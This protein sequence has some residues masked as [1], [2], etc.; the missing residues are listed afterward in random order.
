MRARASHELTM[1]WSTDE[2]R[3]R[4]AE[5]LAAVKPYGLRQTLSMHRQGA[6]GGAYGASG[7][8]PREMTA[9]FPFVGIHMA[10]GRHAFEA[11]EHSESLEQDG[12]CDGSVGFG[13]A[14]QGLVSRCAVTPH[15]SVEK[16]ART[17]ASFTVSP[18]I[19]SGEI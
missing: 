9:Q 15:D 3:F 1:D 4:F 13:S 6:V 17:S 19:Q 16:T 10:V 18:S 14:A 2:P 8:Q 11:T 5:V 12:H 7:S